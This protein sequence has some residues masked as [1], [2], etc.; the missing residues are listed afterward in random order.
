MNNNIS[1]KVKNK[2][3]QSS[4]WKSNKCSYKAAAVKVEHTIKHWLYSESRTH[5]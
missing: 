3:V 2:K 4:E 5:N 1:T